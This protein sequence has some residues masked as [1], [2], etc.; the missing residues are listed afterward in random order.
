M[1]GVVHM[2]GANV[3]AHM[4]PPQ[5]DNPR[6]FFESEKIV[7]LNDRLLS[8][9]GTYWF[10]WRSVNNEWPDN[11]IFQRYADEA[12][13]ILAEEYGAATFIVLKDPRFAKVLPFWKLVLAKSRF[14]VCHVIPIR[15]PDEVADS[16]HKRDALPKNTT[17]L[18]WARHFLDAEKYSRDLPRTFVFWQEFV[19][20][21]EHEVVR[22]ATQLELTWPRLTDQV[23]VEVEKFL[24]PDL[25]HHRAKEGD[26]AGSD[27]GNDYVDRTYAAMRS[28]VTNPGSKETL[29]IFDAIRADFLR[30]ERIYGPVYA[31]LDAARSRVERE[32]DEARSRLAGLDALIDGTARD[33]DA[34]LAANRAFGN[35]I[36][37]TKA[38][39]AAVGQQRDAVTAELDQLRTQSAQTRSLLA[40]TTLRLDRAG[41][42]RSELSAEIDRK[43][44]ETETLERQ[45]SAAMQRFQAAEQCLTRLQKL[46]MLQKIICVLRN[47]ERYFRPDAMMAP[48][49]KSTGEFDGEIADTVPPAATLGL[50]ELLRLNGVQFFVGAYGRLLKRKPDESGLSHYLPRL[51]LGTPKIQLLAEIASSEEARTLAVNVPGLAS[52]VRTFRLSRMPLIGIVFRVFARVEGDSAIDRRLRAI[53]QALY[54]KNH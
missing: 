5:P 45:L 36:I 25:R 8:D 40:D 43:T 20:G 51:M 24:S 42:E 30:T 1:A 14:R 39:L 47:D 7:S 10:D 22:M 19:A 15:H 27:S 29:G 11:P 18:I 4:L 53:E 35:E 54:A 17:R 31:D 12:Q 23:R 38:Q 32:R 3:P 46:S 49:V 37:R 34:A 9:S 28:L 41:Q 6:G 52:A 50:R 2:L 21:W 13:R 44:V 48:A 33:R 16:L 26:S